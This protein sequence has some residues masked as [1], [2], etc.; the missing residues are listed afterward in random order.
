MNPKHYIAKKA[1]LDLPMYDT[2]AGKSCS[3]ISEKLKCVKASCSVT[4]LVFTCLA[5]T[6][7][8]YIMA[9]YDFLVKMFLM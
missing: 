7:E 9:L 2:Y 5:S 8:C 6:F 4:K 3:H 1:L